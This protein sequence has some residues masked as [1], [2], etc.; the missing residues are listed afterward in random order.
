MFDLRANGEM[1]V[2]HRSINAG[3]DEKR[4]SRGRI[5]RVGD[6]AF[7]GDEAVVI[8]GPCSVET[9]SQIMETAL[10]VKIRGASML[11]GGAFKPRTSPHD[12]QG[13]GAEGIKL[14]R[15][16]G[17]A[18]G[19]PVVTEIMSE[20]DIAIGCDHA[21]MIQIGARNM[22][23]FSLLKKLGKMDRPV[24]LK[25]GFRLRSKNGCSRRNISFRAETNASCSANAASARSTTVSGLRSILRPSRL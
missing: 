13:L 6:V 15:R 14:L 24:L 10:G 17:D 25:R 19:L 16:A 21:D 7:G 9:E 23:N 2:Q 3:G 5:V 1:P 11:R 20:D 12:F 22:Q 18:V 4:T 8:A